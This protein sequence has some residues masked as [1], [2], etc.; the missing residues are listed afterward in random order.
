MARVS[1]SIMIE[2]DADLVWKLAGD[3]AIVDAPLPLRSYRS[4][5]AVEE[6]DGHAHVDWVAEFEPQRPQDETQLAEA[7][8]ATYR[9]GLESLR[10]R[11]EAA[12]A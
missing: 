3:P 12:K 7:F 1:E 8:A 4:R 10:G 11:L 5:L 6:H 9:S 2:A